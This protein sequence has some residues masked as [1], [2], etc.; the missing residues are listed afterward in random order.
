MIAVFTDFIGRDFCGFA[1]RLCFFEKFSGFEPRFEGVVV[2]RG[3][4]G[5]NNS[6]GRYL[7]ALQKLKDLII[8]EFC[9]LADCENVVFFGRC[10]IRIC[11]LFV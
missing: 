4:L 8:V 3:E 10:P 7:V 9:E 6:L 11:E 2:G 5:L 1:C